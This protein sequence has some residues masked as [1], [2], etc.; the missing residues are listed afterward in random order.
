MGGVEVFLSGRERVGK[1]LVL[2]IYMVLGL[3]CW[4]VLMAAWRDGTLVQGGYFVLRLHTSPSTDP[5]ILLHPNHN[6]PPTLSLLPSVI[7]THSLIFHH[8]VA[9]P[10]RIRHFDTFPIKFYPTA[11]RSESVSFRDVLSWDW[12][13]GY[14]LAGSIYV[15]DCGNDLVPLLCVHGRE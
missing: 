4:V 8:S 15:A 1:K 5:S 9:Q 14:L 6:D 10:T 12:E 11:V 3:W 2:F 13:H 7:I